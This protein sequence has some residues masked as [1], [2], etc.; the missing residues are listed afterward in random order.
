MPLPAIALEL[1]GGIVLPYI[2]KAL[3]KKALPAAAKAAMKTITKVPVG[4][5]MAKVGDA[6]PALFSVKDIPK[7]AKILATEGMSIGTPIVQETAMSNVLGKLGSATST[8][9]QVGTRVM[10]SVLSLLGRGVQ[11]GSIGA[12]ELTSAASRLPSL[13][14]KTPEDSKTRYGTTPAEQVADFIATLGNAAGT[15]VAAL[16]GAVGTTLDDAARELKLIDIQNA[17]R[18][19]TIRELSDIKELGV[20]PS[21][22]ALYAQLLRS[23]G[24]VR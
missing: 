11:A 3:G 9:G 24:R 17:L 14:N 16:G 23:Q 20:R 10:P 8:I 5:V 7:G 13:V 12:G 15:T 19:R 6:A 2:L 18:D 4:Q 1:A 21:D 22:A